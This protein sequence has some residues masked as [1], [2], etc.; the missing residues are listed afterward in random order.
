MRTGHPSNRP[1]L[2]RGVLL[3][4]FS[5]IIGLNLGINNVRT[6]LNVGATK[7]SELLDD[8]SD[9]M[10]DLKTYALEM[11]STAALISYHANNLGCSDDYADQM[12]AIGDASETIAVNAV[13]IADQIGDLPETLADSSDSVGDDGEAFINQAGLALAGLGGGGGGFGNGDLLA[14]ALGLVFF[15]VRLGEDDIAGR[16]FVPA[17]GPFCAAKLGGCLE[18]SRL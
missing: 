16:A 8:M 3:V 13:L 7:M 6:E 10:Y 15:V 1:M 17:R 12:D 14:L 4:L 9:M 11:N 18:S 5:L 2:A